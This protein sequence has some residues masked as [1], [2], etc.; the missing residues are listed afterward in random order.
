MA[1]IFSPF[2]LILAVSLLYI[3]WDYHKLFSFNLLIWWINLIFVC[4]ISCICVMKPPCSWWMIFMG[5]GILSATILLS[6]IESVFIGDIGLHY[7]FFV[8][9]W[10]CFGKRVTYKQC[11]TMLLLL[12]LIWKN[13]R[14]RIIHSSFMLWF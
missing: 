3:A 1:L 11:W 10:C 4:W 8:E 5:L 14:N 7:Y 9:P 2:N 6:I 12:L 13:L